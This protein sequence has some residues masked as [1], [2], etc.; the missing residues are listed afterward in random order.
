MLSVSAPPEESS[1]RRRARRTGARGQTCR[2]PIASEREV[3]GVRPPAEKCRVAERTKTP[4]P[5]PLRAE[6][7]ARRR[8][9]VR[10]AAFRPRPTRRRL[11]SSKS[12]T[13]DSFNERTAY[14]MTLERRQQEREPHPQLRNEAY[15]KVAKDDERRH[16]PPQHQE[17]R[18]P[19]DESSERNRRTRSLTRS[20]CA[21]RGQENLESDLYF[22]SN[23]F[24]LV[25]RTCRVMT[26][27]LD[28]FPAQADFLRAVCA[29]VVR[30]RV[31]S[32]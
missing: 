1:R 18:R 30:G 29:G 13:D 22:G 28:L 23:L 27:A 12:K 15:V 19:E 7:G 6:S 21:E 4:P 17:R 9:A 3:N 26:Y 2:L 11:Q 24:Q 20:D 16:A 31:P 32:A 5:L 14:V 8:S 25:T 10:P